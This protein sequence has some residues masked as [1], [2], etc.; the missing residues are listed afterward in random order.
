M[1]KAYPYV[2][3]IVVL[4]MVILGL[5]LYILWLNYYQTD[6]TNKT[7]NQDVGQIEVPIQ[8]QFEDKIVYTNDPGADIEAL[9]ADCERRGGQFDSCG[10]AC[11]S[12]AEQCIQ[13]CA[14]VCYLTSTGNG[15]KIT[16]DINDWQRFSVDDLD[17]TIMYP[18]EMTYS[19]MSE[20]YL[21]VQFNFWGPTQTPGTELFD[22]IGLTIQK[23]TYDQADLLAY[24]ESEMAAI[25]P[26]GEV[27]KAMSTTT[28][29]GIEGYT[30]T[31]RTLGEVTKFY[32]PF[33]GNNVLF[34]DYIAPDP[35]NLDYQQIINQIL[36]SLQVNN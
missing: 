5:L 10:S 25:E 19:T 34:V 23:R 2:I 32:L 15:D 31:S 21:G 16:A 1:K 26:I 8:D 24:V 36:Q 35:T 14:Y 6:Q 9:Q 4:A 12:D 22:G 7:A 13:V 18:P 3:L 30:F 20:P 33:G 27:T 29:A 17:I 28:L 11:P